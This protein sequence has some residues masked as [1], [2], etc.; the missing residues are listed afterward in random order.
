[1]RAPGDRGPGLANGGLNRLRIATA[2]EG[3]LGLAAA[4]WLG[5]LGVLLAAGVVIVGAAPDSGA[6]EHA[7][8]ET[9]TLRVGVGP[10]SAV[11]RLDW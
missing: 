5:T 7:V 6:E 8:A 2:E 10:R 9:S 1:M 11:L 4:H 3:R